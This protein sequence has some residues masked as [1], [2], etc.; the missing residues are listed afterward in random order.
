VLLRPL[1]LIFPIGWIGGRYTTS[2]F[3][4]AMAGSRCAAVLKVPCLIGV[5][6]GPTSA[7]SER[8]KNS[9]QAEN[10]AR[11][12]ST[13]RAYDRVVVMYCRTGCCQSRSSSS[14]AGETRANSE[15]WS[16]RSAAAASR[17]RSWSASG[18]ILVA[19]SSTS[20]PSAMSFARSSRPC[21]APIFLTTALR[22]VRYGSSNASTVNVQR[23]TASG[24]ITV[25]HWSSPGVPGRI[26]VNGSAWPSGPCHTTLTP[27]AWCP[28]R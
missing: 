28:S 16:S 6:S 14:S 3:I 5:A 1:R 12:R 21:P 10:R 15:R 19:R 2:K 17:T 9:Y 24:R 27:S 7:P 13:Q 4:A 23:P 20:A 11:L 18:T 25:C 8:G 22:Q 26:R